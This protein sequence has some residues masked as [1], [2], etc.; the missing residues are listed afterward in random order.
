MIWRLSSGLSTSS[1]K[2]GICWGPVSIASYMCFS[3]T[4]SRDGANRPRGSA[5]PAPA[6]LWQAVQLVRKNS[7]PRTT[8]SLS[9][10]VVPYSSSEGTAGPGPSEATY[11]ASASIS[12][13]L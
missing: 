5:P 3:L 13:L 11:A 7:P 2:T 12:S 4:P 9:M 8:S 10:S 6:K 1:E